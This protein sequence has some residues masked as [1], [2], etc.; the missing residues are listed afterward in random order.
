MNKVVAHYT[1]GRLLKGVTGDFAPAKDVF[2]VV[3]G[4]GLRPV[5]VRTAQLK[6]LFFVRDLQGN[7]SHMEKGAFDPAHPT[8][9]RKLM[10]TFQDGEHLVG[11]T[12][13][14]QPDRPGFF[15]IPA[16]QAS[17]IERCYVLGAAVKSVAFL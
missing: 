6:A 1:D 15:M 9:G 12:Q 5:E 14:Y 11:S 7:P 8:P 16:D 4:D 2:H 10:V 3:P 13:G 17:N